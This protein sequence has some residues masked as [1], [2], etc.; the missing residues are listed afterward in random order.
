M[1]KFFI[2][3]ILCT[4]CFSLPSQN[5]SLQEEI[6]HS[7]EKISAAYRDKYPDLT[8]KRG[9]VILEFGEESPRARSKKWEPW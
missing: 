9:A 5:V 3:F 1:K 7:I 4:V 8:V 2:V 6:S